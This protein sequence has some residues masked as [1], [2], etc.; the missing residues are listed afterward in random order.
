MKIVKTVPFTLELAKKVINKE[1]EGEIITETNLPVRIICFDKKTTSEYP[2]I[3]L[4]YYSSNESEITYAYTNEGKA[5]SDNKVNLQIKLFEEIEEHEYIYY[6]SQQPSKLLHSKEINKI[7]TKIIVDGNIIKNRYGNE[8]PIKSRFK[9]FDKVLVREDKDHAWFAT[10]F[11]NMDKNGW[12][13]STNGYSY[14][15]CISYESNEY[16]IGTTDD[17]KQVEENELSNS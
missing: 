16:L 17:P 2:I 4:V 6:F 11:S 5:R 15:Q 14:E 10:F 7:A 8:G 3:G 12:Y 1:V 9:P 13:V